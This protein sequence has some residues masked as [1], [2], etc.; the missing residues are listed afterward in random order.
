MKLDYVDIRKFRSIDQCKITLHDITAIVGQN[1]SGKSAIIRALNAFFNYKE[2]E[3]HFINGK[4]QYSSSSQSKI[5]ISFSG[6][7]KISEL[8]TYCTGD[9]LVI[10]MTYNKKRI[11]K[12]KANGK[13]TASPDNIIDL[14]KEHVAFVYIP[15]NRDPVHMKWEEEALLKK[16]IEEFLRKE[17]KNRDTITPKFRHAV[18]YLEHGAMSKISK[19]VGELYSLRHKFSF[20][21]SFDKQANFASF[22]TGIQLLVSESGKTYN[23]DDCGTGLQSL[24]IIAF[25]RALAKLRH[26][27]I[28][29]GLE[30]PETSLH[31][32]A[33]REL[34]NSIKNSA[35]DDGVAQIIVTTH[36][37]VFVDNISHTQ[38]SLVRKIPDEH[39]GFKTEVASIPASFFEDHGLDEFR[40]S[41]FHNYKNSDFFYANYVILVEGKGDSEVVKELAR[42]EKIDL[43]LHGIS[44][45]NFDGVKNLGYLLH[46]AKDLG[47]PHLVVVDKDY[48]IPYKSDDLDS[49]RGTDGIPKYRYEFKTKILLEELI[50][51]AKDR[52]ILLKLLKSNHSK[53]MDI[54]EKGNVICMNY[55]LEID[56]ICSSKAVAEFG[57]LLNLP[58]ANTNIKH[59]LLNTPKAIKQTEN[60]LSVLRQLDN[61]NLPNSFKRIKNTVVKIAKSI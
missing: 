50:P 27:N 47:L 54:L 15:P 61:A 12:H 5:E 37:T 59:L 22:L 58:E 25:H 57:K 51:D 28:I 38:I 60:I 34:I 33:Q 10:Q 32:Q 1:N 49:S 36:S 20:E 7:S 2:E 53:A 9:S 56:L 19:I 13:F 6:A 31:P 17:T 44:V 39:R 26:K 55:N 8:K 24:T 23:L 3:I 14:L 45:V 21:L 16:L 52:P 35:K 43:D 18:E 11:L 4:H 40:Y 41:Q 48:F 29:L 42:R 46:I 30:E